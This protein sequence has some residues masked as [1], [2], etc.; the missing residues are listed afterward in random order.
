[1]NGCSVFRRFINAGQHALSTLPASASAR[2]SAA[3]ARGKLP[4]QMI[5]KSPW[6]QS[7]HVIDPKRLPS[8]TS[9]AVDLVLRDPTAL[10]WPVVALVHERTAA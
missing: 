1:M 2:T 3:R 10:N 4:G 6:L 9:S 5:G 7:V 8:V